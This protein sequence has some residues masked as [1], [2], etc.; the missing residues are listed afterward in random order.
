MMDDSLTP[1][2]SS[3]G[4]H[5]VPDDKDRGRLWNVE[6]AFHTDMA[7]CIWSLWKLQSFS[8]PHLVCVI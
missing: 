1:P 6:N 2:L 7:D 5:Q 3:I 4:P 8:L